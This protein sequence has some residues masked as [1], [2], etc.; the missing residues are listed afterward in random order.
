MGLR[1]TTTKEEINISIVSGSNVDPIGKSVSNGPLSVESEWCVDWGLVGGFKGFWAVRVAD[2][3]D[4]DLGR[5]EVRTH[6][7][8]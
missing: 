3:G 5:G 1:N 6:L 4:I 8:L 2:E 7:G